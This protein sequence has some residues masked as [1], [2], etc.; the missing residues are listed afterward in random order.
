[1]RWSAAR[2]ARARFDRTRT[3]A[4]RLKAEA[5]VHGAEVRLGR[6][7]PSLVERGDHLADELDS[8]DLRSWAIDIRLDSALVVLRRGDHEEARRRLRAVRVPASAPLGVR[9]RD[10]DVRAALAERT[11]RPS[12]ALGH[13]RA[14]A[15]RPARVAELVR[16]PRPA[17]DGDRARATSRRARAPGGE[18]VGVAGGALRVVRAG[19]D[20]G[21]PRAA[22]AGA[23]RR[24]GWQPISPSSAR[25]PPRRRR[26][27]RTPYARPSCGSGYANARGGP[28]APGRTTTRCRSRTSRRGWS[29]RALVA[30]VV[31]AQRVVALVV[32]EG[33]ATTHDLGPREA[34]ESLLGG[35]LPGLDMAAAHL[36]ESFARS[37]RAEVTTR[38]ARLDDLLLA[39]LADEIGDRPL[40]LTPSG[41]LAAVP[42]T[43]LP[44]NRGRPVIV[45]ESATSWAAR[46]ETSLRSG[47]AGF[48]AGPRVP[49]AEAE[50]SAAAKVWPRV[51]G[52]PRGRGDRRGG[53]PDGRRGRRPAR[54]G[55]RT[56]L[57]GEPALLRLRARRRAVVR[58]R[59]RPAG[60][61]AGRRPAVGV[62]GR[63]LDRCAEARS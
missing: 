30:H 12:A 14:R 33:R 31:T 24:A 15:G 25:W 19:P 62:R 51:A 45:A 56:A 6:T 29:G 49:Q 63:A 50:T 38:V 17:D 34:L 52:A 21:Q 22:G 43:L 18:P 11:G 20:A 32:T 10:R 1:M 58:L 61:G 2:A 48:V 27:A 35:L 3:P 55:A 41:A 57:V 4:L 23:A 13:L 54:L 37:V 60:A 5:L 46:S 53:Q 59:H 28:V 44:T 26:R 16:Q 47:T 7:R 42:W 40:V 8:L 9:L 36:P 39:P